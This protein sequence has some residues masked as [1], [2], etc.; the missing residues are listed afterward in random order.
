MWYLYAQLASKKSDY[1]KEVIVSS[2]TLD[3]RPPLASGTNIANQ[4][5]ITAIVILELKT[6]P[7]ICSVEGL[8][9]TSSMPESVQ[10]GTL[11][12][13]WQQ[14]VCQGGRQG[15]RTKLTA[16]SCVP[17]SRAACNMKGVLC[18]AAK[19]GW[20]KPFLLFFFHPRVIY[21]GGVSWADRWS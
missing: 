18:S 11:L 14:R 15:R 16:C 8:L 13:S 7:S 9:W 12:C 3:C 6:R 5:Q 21:M 17:D 20:A 1:L 4:C 19:S 10:E 2:L